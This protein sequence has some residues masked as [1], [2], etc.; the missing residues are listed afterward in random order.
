MTA[1]GAQTPG[2]GRGVPGPAPRQ[3][4]FTVLGP[5]GGG[6]MQIP[7]ISPHDP[8]LVV[9]ACDMTGAY[10]TT[11]G[12]LS[13]RMFNLRTGVRSYAFDPKDP[14]VIYAGNGLLWRSADRG[15]TWH[16]LFPDPTRNLQEH[17]R[18]DHGDTSFSSDDPL[19]PRDG[20]GVTV[21]VIAVDPTDS[22]HL[23]IAFGAGRTPAELLETKDGGH[24]WERRAELADTSVYALSVAPGASG[25]PPIVRA[26]G[27]EHVYEGQGDR[28]ESFS[29]PDQAH[30]LAGSIGR[31]SKTG[32][33]LLYITAPTRWQGNAVAG[34]LYVSEDGGRTWRSGLEG[35]ADHLQ[36]PGEGRPPLLH[37]IAC[38]GNAPDVA[39]VGFT[40]LRLG[41][42]LEGLYNGIAKTTDGGRHW[43]IV[44][45]ESR[46]LSDNLEGSWIEQRALE[47]SDHIWLDPPY[48]L[49]VAPNEPDVCYATDLFRTYRTADGGRT[50]KQVN[51]VDRGED[52]W[53]TRGLDVT[54]CYGVHFDPFDAQHLIISYTDIGAFQSHDGG[55]SWT[56]ATVGIPNDW[57]NTTYWVVFDPQVKDKLW[58][59]FSYVHDLPRPKMW[60]NRST[61]TYRGG[62]AV[63]TDGGKHWTPS[64]A[65]MPEMAPTH[66]LL[67]PT[68]PAGARTLYVCGFGTGVYK[69]TDDGKTWALKN[70]G[71]ESPQPFAWRLTRADDGALYLIVARRSED[72]RIGDAGDGALYRSTDGAEHWTRMGLPEGVNGPAGLTLDPRDSRRIYLAAWGRMTPGG[73]TGGGVYL[74]TDAGHIWQPI[75]TASQH[76]YD[77]TLDPHHPD[78]LYICGFDTAAYRSTD[79]GATWNRIKGYNFKWGHRVIPDPV[80]PTQIYITTFGGSLWHGPATGDPHAQE[81]VATPIAVTP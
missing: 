70:N 3:D 64:N 21:Q 2:A 69:S 76:V 24:T 46:L 34:G 47:V 45:K 38:A 31:S 43:A 32:R 5:G 30:A 6:T 62:V 79:R 78:T 66:I 35:I 81:D 17:H 65:G 11:D 52:R 16:V 9:E 48:S 20:R 39:Y 18:G 55:R 71:I 4:A 53:T 15:K 12:A 75:F 7:T 8:N 49:G 59:V 42:G 50:W 22:K 67:D 26:I 72:G 73:D 60:R 19:Y 23:V 63:S 54:T 68:S 36:A 56:G 61:E 77:L 74:S 14:D 25:E 13:W 40:H 33:A 44:H 29:I 58:G 10:L 37:A 28:W 51:S 27:R 1:S 57:R 41:E 80:D